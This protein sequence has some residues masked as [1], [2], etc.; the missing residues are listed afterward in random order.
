MPRDDQAGRDEQDRNGDADDNH[1][2]DAVVFGRFT[3]LS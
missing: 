2:E 1:D 3:H